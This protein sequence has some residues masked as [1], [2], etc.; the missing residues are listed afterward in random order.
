MFIFRRLSAFFA[1][2]LLLL[3]SACAPQPKQE[4]AAFNRTQAQALVEA[5]DRRYL[6]LES[7][8]VVTRDTYDALLAEE[9][10]LCVADYDPTLDALLT[11]DVA[12]STGNLFTPIRDQFWPTIFHEG[13][14]ITDATLVRID[15]KQETAQ[16][17]VTLSY[18][19][20]D[21]KLQNWSRGYTFYPQEDGSWLLR[22]CSGTMNCIGNGFS[23]SYL[24]L[25]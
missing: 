4:T 18:T 5:I 9:R 12:D 6:A 15:E 24:P 17:E 14:E 16:L 8:T 10:A 3:A 23:P 21:E 1:L 20:D 7:A 19:G 2:A 13:V 22:A 11:Q 25:K